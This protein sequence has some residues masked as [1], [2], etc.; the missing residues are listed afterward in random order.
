M[1]RLPILL[2]LACA[3]VCITYGIGGD[4]FAQAPPYAELDATPYTPGVDAD[5][6]MF[7][8]SWR[9]STPRQLHGSLVARDI[10]TALEGDDPF[11]PTRRGA[12]LVNLKTFCY[13]TLSPRQN[14]AI[15][16]E[17][18]QEVYYIDRG[19]GTITSRGV[20]SEL[21]RGVGVLMPPDVE[22]TLENTG[23]GDL[24]MYVMGERIPDGFTPNTAMK[25]V[26]EADIELTGFTG[27]WSHIFRYLFKQEDGLATLVGM[28]PCQFAPM[29]MGQP[30]S[31]VSEVEEIW[32]AVDEG[33]NILLGK[34]LRE[35]S[36]GTAYKIPPNG[37]TP[38]SNINVTDQTVTLFW[39]MHIPTNEVMLRDGSPIRRTD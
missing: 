20:T 11:R 8:K 4:A 32:F 33:I 19:H 15:T 13:A 35:L 24:S 25:V 21:Y 3:C 17:D 6:D 31:H 27:H 29:S 36:P 28:G 7:I 23:D 34:Q 2:M 18:T 37:M 10:F 30:H 38:H 26:D 1:T 9:E 14:T 12:V 39:F 16:L 5:P 22:F